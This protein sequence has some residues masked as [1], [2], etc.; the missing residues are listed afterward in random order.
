MSAATDAHVAPVLSRCRRGLFDRRRGLMG[1]TV[2]VEPRWLA[3]SH[4]ELLNRQLPTNGH[5]RRLVHIADPHAGR[6]TTRAI[7]SGP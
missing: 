6:V 4:R 3:V 1:W 7:H 5:G 2:V